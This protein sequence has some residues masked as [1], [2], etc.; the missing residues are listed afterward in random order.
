MLQTLNEVLKYA[1]AN[2]KAIGAFNI[3][4]LE[5]LDAVIDAAEQV[6]EPVIIM[7][8]EVHEDEGVAKL[9]EIGPIMVERAKSSTTDVVV[10]LDHGKD[11]KMLTKALEHGFTS[12]MYDGSNLP[13]EENVSKTKEAVELASKYNASVE[14]EIGKMTRE[15]SQIQ[16]SQDFDVQSN[17][18]NPQEASMFVEATGVDCLACSFGTA[19]GLYITE[20]KLDLDLVSKI[21]TSINVPIVMHGGSGV[22]VEDYKE[23]IKRGVRKIN[24]YTYMAK[25]GGEAVRDFIHASEERPVFYH[26][27]VSVGRKAMTENVKSA[28]KIFSNQ[29]EQEDIKS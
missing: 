27:I 24:Y 6:N 9:D 28:I 1:E 25:A 21:D 20:P 17:H 3:T 16:E 23:V 12:I 2:D 10:H 7:F 26:E 29:N 14:G 15:S 19:H 11:F 8:A 18:T 22:T 4:C 13:Y 5:T